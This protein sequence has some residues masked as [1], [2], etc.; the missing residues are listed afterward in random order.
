MVCL[1]LQ[2]ISYHVNLAL[3][4]FRIIQR[5][6]VFA[7]TTDRLPCESSVTNL[8]NHTILLGPTAST[9]EESAVVDKAEASMIDIPVCGNVLSGT[10][11][12]IIGA[13]VNE[14]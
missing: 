10:H 5:I 4:V 14:G 9:N 7:S 2:R 3:Q 8:S 1:R 6:D 13:T 12:G 11:D